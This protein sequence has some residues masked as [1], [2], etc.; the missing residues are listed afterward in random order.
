MVFSAETELGKIV[1]YTT[2]S[3]SVTAS[4]VLSDL[5]VIGFDKQ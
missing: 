2:L 1:T 3:V 4:V 5:E